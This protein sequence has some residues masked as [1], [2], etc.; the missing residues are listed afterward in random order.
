M[1]KRFFSP[2]VIILGLAILLVW[3]VVK[4]KPAEEKILKKAAQSSSKLQKLIAKSRVKNNATL[5]PNINSEELITAER[6]YT[7]DEIKNTTE[8][9]FAEMLKDTE[10]RL[11]T[12]G[13]IKQLPPGALHHIPSVILEAGR[14]LGAL[15]EVFKFHPEYE[16]NA[17]PLYTKCALASN[18]PTPVRALCLTNLVEISKKHN[19]SLDLKRF[20]SQVV[21]LTKLV[22]DM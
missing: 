11:P 9:Q 4:N 13:D 6:I 17:I 14:N 18:R 10:M 12:L 20:P 5:S 3:A 21:E 8:M 19:Q 16:E 22:T 2:V 7:E 15:K 1:K